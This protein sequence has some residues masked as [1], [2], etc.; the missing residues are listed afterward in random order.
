VLRS[1][2]PAFPGPSVPLFTVLAG[3]SMLPHHNCLLRLK[4]RLAGPLA[5]EGP[6]RSLEAKLS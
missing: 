5:A 2:L 4:L 1:S 6:H 3:C